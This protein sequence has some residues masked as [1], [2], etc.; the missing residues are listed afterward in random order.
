M[1][2]SDYFIYKCIFILDLCFN[3]KYSLDEEIFFKHSVTVYLKIINMHGSLLL[4]YSL[5]KIAVFLITIL[6]E[7]TR[8]TT[9]SSEMPSSYRCS[10][11]RWKIVSQSNI[12]GL[13]RIFSHPRR[14][15]YLRVKCDFCMTCCNIQVL[16][17]IYG[18]VYY[19][20]S[21]HGTGTVEL[22]FI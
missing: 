19:Q 17:N 9:S 18:H 14:T 8:I 22:C 3:N 21:N 1:L 7:L 13:M 16:N 12:I 10:L 4:I 6:L 20:S 11:P 5:M 15:K 2:N